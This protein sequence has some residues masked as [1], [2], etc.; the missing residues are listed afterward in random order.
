MKFLAL[1]LESDPEHRLTTLLITLINTG[2]LP[3]SAS[4]KR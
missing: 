3:R 1:A 2:D 4:T